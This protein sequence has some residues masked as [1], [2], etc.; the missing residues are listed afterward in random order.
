MIF[1]LEIGL[2]KASCASSQGIV[3]VLLDLYSLIIYQSWVWYAVYF[4]WKTLMDVKGEGF[5]ST[6]QRSYSLMEADF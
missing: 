1:F 4:N 2:S 6:S 3:C 5:A